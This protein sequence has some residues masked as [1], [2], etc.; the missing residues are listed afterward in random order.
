[1]DVFD[2]FKCLPDSLW[3]SDCLRL[4]FA[5]TLNEKIDTTLVFVH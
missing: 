3:S 1:M 2:T 4:L 5:E